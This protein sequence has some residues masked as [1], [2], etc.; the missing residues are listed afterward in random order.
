MNDIPDLIRRFE[1]AEGRRPRILIAKMGQD[2]HD[3]GAK[4]VATA[5]ADMG[6]DVDIG[7]LFQTPAETAKQAVE[8]DVH[9]V[10]MSSLAA[11]HKTLLPQLA[12][13]LAR[14]G[15]EDILIVVG[16]VIPAQDYPFLYE[17]GACAI[18]GPGTVIPESARKILHLLIEQVEGEMST[19]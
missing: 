13:E 18:F 19:E 10:A 17:H 1:A 4:V 11:G 2:G 12:A 6:F 3:R 15:R 16:G 9:I 8:N 7:P 5:Y 14:L